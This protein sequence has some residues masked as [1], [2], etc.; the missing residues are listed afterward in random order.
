MQQ[1]LY[2]K[3][4]KSMKTGVTKTLCAVAVL[5]AAS[6]ACGSSGPRSAS[7]QTLP[8]AVSPDEVAA[9]AAWREAIVL[10]PATE[11]GCFHAAYPSMDWEAI[12]CT[13]ATTRYN[14]R[15]FASR[16]EAGTP[17]T[18]GNGDDFAAEVAS[19]KIS[20][21]T[22]TF[23]TV[24]GVKSE[25]DEGEANTYSI[26]LN[27]NFMSG[28]KACEGV[29]GC[30]S[31]TQFVYSTGEEQAF[32]QDWLIG[33]GNTCP[34]SNF[35]SDGEGDCFTN[36]AAVNV[37]AI[38]VSKL[39]GFKMV[40]SAKAGGKDTLV[41]TAEGDAFSTNQPDTITDLSTDWTASEF[42]IIG[43]GGGS[44]A[45]FNAGSSITVKIALADGSTKA[46]KCV[47]ND[48]TTGET[49]N[50]NLGKC[51]ATAGKTPFIEFVESLK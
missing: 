2:E 31:W 18:V 37:P 11:D 47:A 8:A 29:D 26:Q 7:V 35:F 45:T 16:N 21:A 46:P 49:N 6:V 4:Q 43:D 30:L 48:G 9:R 12:A 28:R 36:S 1:R 50:L 15:P 39:S 14:V 32:M 23:P 41:F 20:S 5:A 27:S 24:T 19:G 33:I 13:T 51:T 25:N 34:N 10:T 17:F 22:G 40:G 44:E 42:N 38:P 3:V